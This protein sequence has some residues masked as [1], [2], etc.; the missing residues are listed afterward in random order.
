MAGC[1]TFDYCKPDP[2]HLT[3][4]VEIMGGDLKKTIMLGDSEVDA[5][6]AQNASMP[7]I[8]VKDGYTNKNSNEIRHDHLI[9]DYI[10]FE[11]IIEKYL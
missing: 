11:K 1:N 5:L 6:S 7:F 4:V 10:N 2:R 3:S 8:L 9:K